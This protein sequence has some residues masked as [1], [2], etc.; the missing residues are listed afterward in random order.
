MRRLFEP[1][2]LAIS[3]LAF[4]SCASSEMAPPAVPQG[5]RSDPVL[6]LSPVVQKIVEAAQEQP[7]YTLRYDP[8]YQVIPYPGG[9]LPRDR[10]V[11]SDVLVRAFRKGARLDLQKAVHEDMVRNFAAYPQK[12]GLDAPDPNIDH[13]RVPNLMT[14][15][16]RRGRAISI[17]RNPEDY[18]PGDIVAW[19]LGNGTLHIGLV[20]R[21]WA[22]ET[23]RYK[24]VHNISAGA[25]IEDRLF[26][27]RVIGHYRYFD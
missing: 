17:T 20:S 1:L 10:G 26:E 27:W 21:E 15:F 25:R 14:F 8:S 16:A 4:L 5:H 12:W 9:D 6:R 3:V 19:D 11:C 18:R 2:L 24:I 7:E 22:E 23:G 13:R